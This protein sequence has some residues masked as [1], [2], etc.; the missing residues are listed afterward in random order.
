[1]RLQFDCGRLDRLARGAVPEGLDQKVLGSLLAL[2]VHDLR[3]PL[4]ALH[5]NVDFLVSTLTDTDEDTRGAL[6]DA[7]V[8]CDSLIAIVDN[9]ELV[10]FSLQGPIERPGETLAVAAVVADVVARQRLLAKSHGIEVAIEPSAADP[11]VRV[12]AHREMFGRAFANLL[13]NA[14][15]HSGGAGV[16]I[17]LEDAGQRLKL[18]VGDAGPALSEDYREVA[19]SAAGQYV[20]KGKAGGRYGRGLGLFA[21]RLAAESAGARIELLR[22][23][24]GLNCALALSAPVGPR[25]RTERPPPRPAGRQF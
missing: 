22:A 16:R 10:A 14:I 6:D 24:E 20:I 13:R 12:V 9:A 21:A 23:P 11:S 25:R 5:S 15:Q 3:N 18:V 19:F 17:W 2:L 1:M 8:S 4:S 7:V